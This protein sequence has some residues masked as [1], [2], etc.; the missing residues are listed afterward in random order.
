MKQNAQIFSKNQV[1]AFEG[2]NTL[3]SSFGGDWE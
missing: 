1:T 2:W 3:A